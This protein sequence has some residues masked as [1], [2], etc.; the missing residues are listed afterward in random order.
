MTD[1]G[2]EATFCY[3]Q[4]NPLLTI[5]D[6]FLFLWMYYHSGLFHSLVAE[7]PSDQVLQKVVFTGS[8]KVGGQINS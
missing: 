6:Y 8:G 4:F 3:T 1:E 2:G 5:L 7:T